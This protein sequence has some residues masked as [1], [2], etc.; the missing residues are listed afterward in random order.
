M[1]TF[2]PFVVYHKSSVIDHYGEEKIS[3]D[4]Q[5][6]FVI[7]KGGDQKKVV[8][9]TLSMENLWLLKMLVTKSGGN[10]KR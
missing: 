5:K 8:I 1:K 6:K 4:N 10:Q 7:E 2:K 3:G 9:K